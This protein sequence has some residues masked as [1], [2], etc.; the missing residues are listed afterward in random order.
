[1]SEAAAVLPDVGNVSQFENLN[2]IYRRDMI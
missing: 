1:M 2:L